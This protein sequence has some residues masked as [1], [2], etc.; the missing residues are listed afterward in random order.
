MSENIFEI[1]L[2]NRR[3]LH[4]ILTN[5]PKEKLLAIPEGFNNN[6]FWNIAHVV[7]TQQIL[8]Y[9]LSG[10]EMRVPEELVDK[11]KKGT[12]PEGTATDNEIK[13]IAKLLVPTIEWTQQDYNA[14]LFENYNQYTTSARV[15]LKD[16]D[17]AMSFN[18][19]HEGLHIGVI[20]LL[21][22]LVG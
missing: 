19:F 5:T 4:S 14:Q 10:L 21:L 20:I 15:T 9:K 22:R 2:Q 6:I 12:V 17:D 8:C 7:V 18:L 3:N 13:T 16:I 1:T 11:F